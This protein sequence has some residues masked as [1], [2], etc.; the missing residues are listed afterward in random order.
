MS[1]ARIVVPIAGD[2]RV[3]ARAGRDRGAGYAQ[4]GQVKGKVVDAKTSR[5]RARSSPSKA[6][7]R[8]AASS[9][10]RRTRA[11]SSSRSA[12]S[13]AIQGHG[14]EG[15]ADADLQPARQPRHGGGE[16]QRSSRAAPAA[17]CQPRIARRP[18]PRTP[19]VKTAFSEGVALSNAGK[20]DEAIAK[21][22]EVLA[23]C[24]SA[25]S[26]TPT[27]ARTTRRRR[28]TPGRGGYKKAIEVDPN[29][30]EAYTGLANVYNAQ[31]KFDQA[32]EA[33]AQAM[34]L[35]SAAARRWRGGRRRQRRRPRSTRA[36]S[37]G[38]PARSPTPR[39]SSRR[40][41]SSTRSWPKRTTGS[42]WRIS[43]KA[44]LTR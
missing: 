8:A 1:G 30:A 4:T 37:C 41:S 29:S 44:S 9:R 24:R 22:N 43:T 16:L 42:A 20:Y 35:S 25:R 26:A 13:R 34:K 36:S 10:S 11:A 3:R 19:Q 38:T 15:R 17:T 6:A 39:S 5:S 27:S 18:R 32:A 14:H 28:T 40:R 2:L 31:K 12:S 33:S 23:R 21:F 7:T